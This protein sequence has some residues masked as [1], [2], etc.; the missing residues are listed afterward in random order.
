MVQEYLNEISPTLHGP[1]KI[2]TSGKLPRIVN[3]QSPASGQDNP[4]TL[5]I[6]LCRSKL[7]AVHLAMPSILVSIVLSSPTYFLAHTLAGDTVEAVTSNT[8]DTDAE[9]Q[10]PHPDPED[11]AAKQII[12][13]ILENVDL[14]PCLG[15]M[16]TPLL[17]FADWRGGQTSVSGSAVCRE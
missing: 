17:K 15:E 4:A 3:L 7:T 2:K 8:P 12:A 5:Y 9:N 13:V 11:A 14:D 6:Y 16:Q 10:H 1:N